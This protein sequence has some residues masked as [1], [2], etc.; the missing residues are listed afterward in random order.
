VTKYEHKVVNAESL[1]SDQTRMLKEKLA[2]ADST[3]KELMYHMLI[4]TMVMQ[5]ELFTR[6]AAQ[7]R[8][9]LDGLPAECQE[10]VA[11]VRNDL[12][13]KVDK[14]SRE[15]SLTDKVVPVVREAAPVSLNPPSVVKSTSMTANS[16]DNSQSVFDFGEVTPHQRTSASAIVVPSATLATTADVSHGNS[17]LGFA[18]TDVSSSVQPNHVLTVTALYDNDAETPDELSF[19]AGEIIEVLDMGE[20]GGGWGRGRLGFSEGLFPLNFVKHN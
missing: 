16:Y 10:A 12:L 5:E 14:A 20:D 2:E 13:F 15:K 4:T 9:V 8:T 1:L 18:T 11:A 7:L 17:T 6:S 19:K 3:N